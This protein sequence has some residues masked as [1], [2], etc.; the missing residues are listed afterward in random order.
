MAVNFEQRKYAISKAIL[1]TRLHSLRHFASGSIEQVKLGE[2]PCGR[3]V[4][5]APSTGE[6]FLVT[7]STELKKVFTTHAVVKLL[8]GSMIR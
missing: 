2:I 4:H 1:C 7:S 3:G 8:R 5:F 6:L